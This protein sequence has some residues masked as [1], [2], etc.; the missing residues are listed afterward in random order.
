M[1]NFREIEFQFHVQ[2]TSF[3]TIEKLVFI[4]QVTC[5]GALLP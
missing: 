4:N 5:V 2:L 3:R 1:V